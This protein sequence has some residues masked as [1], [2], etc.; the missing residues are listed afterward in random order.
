MIILNYFYFY[1][2][3]YMKIFQSGKYLSIY[4]GSKFLALSEAAVS[5]DE[6]L[7]HT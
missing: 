4:Q 3:V 1:N 5:L 2:F 6:Y 7:K